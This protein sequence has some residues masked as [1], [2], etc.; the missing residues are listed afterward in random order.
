MKIDQ[1]KLCEDLLP[2]YEDDLVSPETKEFLEWHLSQCSYCQSK[3]HEIS[4]KLEAEQPITGLQEEER[5]ESAR[6]FLLT[7]R[8]KAKG[9][10]AI[11]FICLVFLSL[12]SFWLG[13]S[14]YSDKPLKVKSADEYA[15]KVV[16]GWNR[17][18]QSGQIVTLDV[19][20]PIEGTQAEVTFEKVWFNER[21]TVVLYTVTDPE[22]NYYQA[23]G[24][25]IDLSPDQT[26]ANNSGMR[27]FGSRFGG[28]SQTGMH[29]IMVFL[30][31]QSVPETDQHL[32]LTIPRWYQGPFPPTDYSRSKEIHSQV[33]VSFEL[34]NAYLEEQT[35]TIVLN[36]TL[37]WNG[38]KITLHKL[39]VGFSKNILYGKIELPPNESNP[40]LQG[41]FKIGDEKAG[42]TEQNIKPAAEPNT[43]NFVVYSNP[44]NEWPA[45]VELHLDGLRF[46]TSEVLT[47]PFSWYKYKDIQEIKSIEGEEQAPQTSYDSTIRLWEIDRKGLSFKIDEPSG[48]KQPIIMEPEMSGKLEILNEEGH[49]LSSHAGGSWSGNIFGNKDIGFGFEIDRTEPFWQ[50]SNTII[51][52]IHNPMA[53]MILDEKIRI[54]PET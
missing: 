16:P 26:M 5:Y 7:I 22:G 53:K 51:L 45:P 30:G 25:G 47:F 12:T 24:E 52:R 4:A 46:Q 36:N 29:N 17:A 15:S 42:F 34:K 18:E 2:L 50:T 19:S 27:P 3:Y 32:T 48:K 6:R 35:E 43:F 41:Y 33:S 44:F 9:I 8:Q 49:I 14:S 28:I 31:Y 20:K 11:I 37:E 21:Y 23:S 54:H 1:C 38:R 40:S 10:A 13:Q 39:E